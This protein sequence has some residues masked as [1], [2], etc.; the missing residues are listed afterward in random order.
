MADLSK[1][2]KIIFD[3]VDNTSGNINLVTSGIQKFA[4]K[5]ENATQPLADFTTGLLKAE[6]AA[7]A[8][9]AAVVLFAVKS[10][11]EFEKALTDLNKV[12]GEGDG[13]IYD[14]IP[15]LKVLC[16]FSPLKISVL[17]T[18]RKQLLF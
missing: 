17:R 16:C 4:D 12:L 13:D 18:E 11:I 6:A 2:I 8:V 5:V 9:G 10:S 1:T 15:K 3:S 14:Y 7:L